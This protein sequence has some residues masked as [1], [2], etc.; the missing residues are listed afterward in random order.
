MNEIQLGDKVRCKVTGFIG[1]A[2]A[3]TV[4][5]N[6]CTQYS[7]TGKVGKDNKLLVENEASI[8]EQSIELIKPKE[9]KKIKKESNGGE[10]RRAFKQRGF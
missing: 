3:K 10:M 6:G 8:D 2:T 5:L 1:I 9:K 4:F 7:V